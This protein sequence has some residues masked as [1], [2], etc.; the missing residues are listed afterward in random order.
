M[1]HHILDR[2]G[3]WNPQLY[4][5][6]K[7]NLTPR[8]LAI[9]ML[10]S[11]GGQVI[12]MLF[13]LSQ[14]GLSDPYPITGEYCHSSQA[15][16][17]QAIYPYPDCPPHLI[18]HTTW[19]ADYFTK[20]FAFLAIAIV[21]T[22]LL[23]G[24]YQLIHN[25]SQEK[26]R[27]TLNFIQLSPQSTSQ[28]LIG[29]LLG[30]PSMV[31]IGVLLTLPLLLGLGFLV[32]IPL[33]QTIGFLIALVASAVF[34]FSVALLIGLATP[35]NLNGLEA[36]VGTGAIAL[37][38]FLALMV[39]SDTHSPG[40][41]VMYCNL[42]VP[43]S[44][45]PYTAKIYELFENRLPIH[46]STTLSIALVVLNYGLLTYWVSRA[47]QR[48]FRDPN[49]NLWSKA[50]SY[51]ITASLNGSM[52]LMLV[53]AHFSTWG[54]R[55]RAT[56]PRHYHHILRND[57]NILLAINLVLLLGWM[58]LLSVPRQ[59]LLDWAR[60]RHEIPKAR[61]V[62]SQSLSLGERSPANLAITFNICISFLPLF[63][64]STFLREE[65]SI[66]L[67][68]LLC[69]LMQL[70]TYA[71]IAQWII[72][73]GMKYASLLAIGAIVGSALLIPFGLN[74]LKLTPRQYPFLWLFTTFNWLGVE[75]LAQPLL[76]APFSLVVQAGIV[77]LL[78][79]IL[80][81]RIH[82]AGQSELKQLLGDRDNTVALR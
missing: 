1:Q 54:E 58:L 81:R 47:L 23:V 34:F 27:G 21:I 12:M 66:W 50:Q 68:S 36:W 53:Y 15:V 65:E 52:L 9:T 63:L 25:L 2:I 75:N 51:G 37:G 60:Y 55:V 69:W 57:F 49:I 39:G 31:Y 29:K 78:N 26:R 22:L 74:L 7:G 38:L 45:L 67:I 73:R 72:W 70:F 64:L 8:N 18:D 4:R 41:L 32:S 28:I 19:Q 16:K 3:D 77:V 35:K 17:E 62:F 79:R 14:M 40:G 42:F 44:L 46:S 80:L 76:F 13:I 6:L 33:W 61:R 59:R 82:H 30:V 20:C 5:E 43:T 24:V 56:W 10:G 11:I 48:C 71:A